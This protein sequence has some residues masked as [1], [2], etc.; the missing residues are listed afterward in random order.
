[1][2]IGAMNATYLEH[3]TRLHKALG[4]PARLRIVAMLSGGEL[5]VCQITAV[6]GLAPSTVSQ[7]LSDLKQ[8]G[9]IAERKE[10][11]WVHYALQDSPEVREIV[12]TAG[13]RLA[14]DPVAAADAAVLWQLRRVPVKEL[15]RVDLDLTRLAISRPAG[16]KSKLGHRWGRAKE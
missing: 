9:L 15:C 11:R 7:H 14:G 5:C 4:H 16:A 3:A 6:L 2:Y 12:A 1:M 8:A 10:G 13:P